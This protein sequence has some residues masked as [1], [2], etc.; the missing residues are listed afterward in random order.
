M[1]HSEVDATL[2]RTLGSVAGVALLL[3]LFLSAVPFPS[4]AA[5]T[6]RSLP[7]AIASSPV[8]GNIS[9][10]TLL[11]LRATGA[12]Y[13]I[14]GSGGPAY[15]AN[16]SLVGNVTYHATVT[17]PNLTGV[18]FTPEEAAL[19]NNS[20]DR[21][22]LDVGNTSEVLTIV[23]EV[24]SAYKTENQSI[25]V[26]WT[27]HVVQPYIVRATL[28]A[29]PN[30]TVSPFTVLV[31]LDGVLVG[32][33]S[34]PTLLPNESYQFSYSYATLGLS[35]G[36]HTFTLYLQD[37]HGLVVFAGGATIYS[38][39]FNVPGASP[40]YTLW[41][42]AGAVAFFGTTFI[43]VTRLAARRRGQGRR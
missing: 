12:V 27:V 29:G 30:A 23:V 3:V 22:S 25:N 8:T 9:G 32:N 17:G 36:E 20:P 10:P 41:Y 42:V 21:G 7:A 31:D 39:T 6:G 40:N 43:F 1:A 11:A 24:S 2:N 13:E 19:F 16:G 4:A 15:A 33:V 35:P 26:T 37:P 18:S 34:I 14:R 38:V 5:A 28:V